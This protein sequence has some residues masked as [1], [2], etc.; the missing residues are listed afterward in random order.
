M[1]FTDRISR[2]VIS[3]DKLM[4]WSRLEPLHKS[5]LTKQSPRLVLSRLA[6]QKMATGARKPKTDVVINIKRREEFGAVKWT[7]FVGGE[8]D[9]KTLSTGEH[10]AYE[11]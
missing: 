1:I 9:F 5:M 3:L 6:K 7:Y 11:E 4:D 10:G 8:V 2:H